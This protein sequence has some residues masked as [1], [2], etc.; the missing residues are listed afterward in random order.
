MLANGCQK[1]LGLTQLVIQVL[2][3]IVLALQDTC[4]SFQTQSTNALRWFDLHI[5]PLQL[6]ISRQQ[7][8]PLPAGVI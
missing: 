7:M 2:R 3:P 4:P 1:V 6:V 8:S 5:I